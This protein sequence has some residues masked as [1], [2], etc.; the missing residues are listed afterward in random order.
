MIR[1]IGFL[2]GL[3]LAGCGAQS[4]E[5]LPQRS[6]PDVGIVT[7]A[8][9]NIVPRDELPGRV[10]AFRVA[11]VRPQLSGILVR[12]RFEEGSVVRA[13]QVLYEI[14]PE[15]Y[16]A[17]YDQAEATLD[18]ARATAAS[19]GGKA[20]RYA[21]LVK[22]KGISQQ[23]HE[24][25]QAAYRQALASVKM[26][27]AALRT[28]H[29]NLERTHVMAPISGH[30]GR[31]MVSEGALVTAGQNSAL[32]T[33]QQIDPIYVDLVQPSQD[34]LR[35][36]RRSSAGNARSVTA[37]V[38]LRLEG[39]D[40]YEHTGILKLTELS[41][42]P[43]TGSVTLR[44]QFPNPN[45]LLLPGMYVRAEVDQGLEQTV[46]L[47]PQQAVIHNAK[48]EPTARVIDAANQVEERVL[49]TLATMAD[50]WIVVDGLQAGERLI[51]EGVQRI[52]PGQSVN[53]VEVSNMLDPVA[54]SYDR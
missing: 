30:I 49:T 13:G 9:Q 37:R 40:H 46:I 17:A 7:L 3:A 19:L 34:V 20:E 10:V 39:R 38:T 53:P 32:A 33:I 48:G 11:E 15:S 5:D 1:G 25:A 47:A 12:R 28:A 22:S 36:K 35:F 31:S 8:A 42:D 23:H 50:R 41:V 21:T 16:Q 44:A 54:F 6:A 2:L 43:R 51:V 14:D 29:L 24:D 45:G 4:T 52:A 27:E 18:H 26:Q